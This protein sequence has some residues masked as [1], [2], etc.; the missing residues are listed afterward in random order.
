ML[1]KSQKYLLCVEWILN[2]ADL[3]LFFTDGIKIRHRKYSKCVCVCMC[4]FKIE[5][6]R[7]EQR[8]REKREKEDERSYVY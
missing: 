3:V 1:L 8:D 7:D 6:E 4:V 2:Y 5:E